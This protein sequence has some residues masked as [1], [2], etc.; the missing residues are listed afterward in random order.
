LV[1]LHISE[2]VAVL[3]WAGPW[4]ADADEGNPCKINM[5]ASIPRYTG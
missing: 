4:S 1:G 3:P 5:D 2:E